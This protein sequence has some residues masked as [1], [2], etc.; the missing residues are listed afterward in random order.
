MGD[1]ILGALMGIVFGFIL[2]GAILGN[3]AFK[4]GMDAAFDAYTCTARDIPTGDCL[5]WER[6]P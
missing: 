4:D 6:N 5:V 2:G 3:M 1:A